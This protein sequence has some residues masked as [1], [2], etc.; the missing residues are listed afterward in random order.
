MQGITT[1]RTPPD[2]KDHIEE[3]EKM[4]QRY[5]SDLP[6]PAF[7][8][9][10]PEVNTGSIVVL[11]TG[12]TGNVGAHI[13]AAL[14]AEPMV[15]RVYT[16][17][18][19]S[20][21]RIEDRQAATFADRGL[22]VELLGSEK[23]VQLVGDIGKD[24]FGLEDTLYKEVSTIHSGIHASIF[25]SFVPLT[26]CRKQITERVTHIVHNAWRVDFN[27]PLS[28]FE[29]HISGVRRLIDF[30]AAL[31]RRVVLLFVS[32]IAATHGWDAERGPVPEEVLCD[33]RL[34]IGTGYGE[35]KFVT[36]NVSPISCPRS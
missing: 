27:V 6:M 11:L 5:T 10:S 3:I 14:L 36:E 34:T 8:M 1:S 19:Q 16:L 35:S 7:A 13:L 26:I 30:C 24:A 22:P 17:N 29:P 21:S 32:S 31:P 2:R 18:R 9:D 20:T 23:L 25:Q 33:P 28:A 15:S 4:V 12:S